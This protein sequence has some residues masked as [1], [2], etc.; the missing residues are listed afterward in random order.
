MTPESEELSV[1]SQ[2]IQAHARKVAREEWNDEHS[3]PLKEILKNAGIEDILFVD[4]RGIPIESI[5]RAIREAFLEKRSRDLTQGLSNRIV[6]EAFK[7]IIQD[8]K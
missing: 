7:K 2:T 8:E 6:A 5:I 4:G 3:E 1:L